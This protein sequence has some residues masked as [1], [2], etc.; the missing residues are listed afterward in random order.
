MVIQWM[1]HHWGGL[2]RW[3]HLSTASVQLIECTSRLSRKILDV[4]TRNRA[5]K[6]D[7]LRKL[8]TLARCGM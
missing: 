8:H 3:D 7:E 6:Q 4:D 2:H 1:R 5:G